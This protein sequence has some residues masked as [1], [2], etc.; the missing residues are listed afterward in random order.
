MQAVEYER[1]VA[2]IADLDI[3]IGE[4]AGERNAQREVGW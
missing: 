3:T 4:S 2:Q 1:M